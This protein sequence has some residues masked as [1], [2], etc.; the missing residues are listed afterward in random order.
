MAYVGDRERGHRVGVR[1]HDRVRRLLDDLE[2]GTRQQIHHLV[3]PLRRAERVQGA[4]DDQRV[5]PDLRQRLLDRVV[6]HLRQHPG[7]PADP[8]QQ[9]R[10]QGQHG[11]PGRFLP[12][13]LQESPAGAAEGA[14]VRAQHRPQ[15][16]DRAERPGSTGLRAGEPVGIAR[17][18]VGHHLG[19]HRVSDQH[20]IDQA[21]L[22][23]HRTD[24]VGVL[25]DGHPAALGVRYATETGQVERMHRPVVVEMGGEALEVVRRDP[26]AGHQDERPLAVEPDRADPGV[27]RLPRHAPDL[28]LGLAAASTAD[29]A[30]A[31]RQQPPGEGSPHVTSEVQILV[32]PR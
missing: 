30:V 3:D 22:V 25:P 19:A 9:V 4:A 8:A 29:V 21:Q 2:P 28:D 1:V 15:Q 23:D 7:E 14:F 32:A 12:G 11:H 24:Q 27:R 18:Q 17:R 20:R 31:H 5:G 16:H 6:H 26:D 10:L 13:R